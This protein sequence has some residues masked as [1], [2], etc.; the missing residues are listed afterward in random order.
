M[1]RIKQVFTIVSVETGG[2]LSESETLASAIDLATILKMYFGSLVVRQEG[3]V[4][5]ASHA[6]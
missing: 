5:W 2:L 6:P 3:Q 1:A 4:M